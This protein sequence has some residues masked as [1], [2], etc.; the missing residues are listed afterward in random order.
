MTVSPTVAT[1]PPSTDGST[2]TFRLTS[3]PVALASAAA[4]RVSWSGVSGDGRAHLGDLEVLGRR[5]PGDELVD[6]RRQVASAAGADDHRDQL[7]GRRRDLATEQILDDRLT[8]AGRDLLVAR[9]RCAALRCSRSCGRSGT[10]RLRPRRSCLRRGR[11]RTGPGR[12]PRFVNRSCAGSCCCSDPGDEAL[13]QRLM[14]RL[15]EGAGDD[16]VDCGSRQAGDLGAQLVAGPGR[17]GSDIGL[18]SGF[19]L[20]DLLGEP[21]PAV[22]EQRCG[23]GVGLGQQ[24]GTLGGDV[25]LGLTDLGSLGLGSDSIRLTGIELCLDL[26]GA[27][28]PCPSSPSGRRTSTAGRRRAPRRGC[29]TASRIPPARTSTASG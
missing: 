7:G 26:G 18:G 14:R 10:T 9:A 17:G 16:V 8:L 20:G 21:G 25:A 11:S 24:P 1:M 13:D 29:R 23:L 28:Q 12:S 27:A 15:V 4:S 3:L 22:F 2:T 19:E 6:D 5:R